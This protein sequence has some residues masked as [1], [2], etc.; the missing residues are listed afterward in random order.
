M[1]TFLFDLDGTLLPLRE[2]E[3][4]RIYF[5]G[6]SRRMIEAGYRKEDFMKALWTGIEAMREN[7]GRAVNEE[8]FWRVFPAA[9]GGAREELEELF[10]DYYREEF[11]ETKKS[12][13]PTPYAA[14]CV[15]A[16]KE[17][18]YRLVLATNPLFP[19]I[20]TYQ[21]IRWAGLEPEDF[22][23]VTTIDNSRYCKPNL[24]YYEDILVKIGASPGDCI[25]VGN[26]VD[27][28]MVAR[29]LG[30]ETYLLLDC[31]IN[32]KG[33]EIDSFRR[34]RITDLYDFILKLPGM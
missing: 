13:S 25:M 15:A 2:E 26:D 18:G 4:A 10:Y 6:L 14:K 23:L 1:N 5:S 16:L 24:K 31:L 8:V 34:G 27:E 29:E 17:K 12:A 21:R 30:C 9:L 3:F 28:D 20:A 22:L 19:P 7:D 32:A 11:F 33:A